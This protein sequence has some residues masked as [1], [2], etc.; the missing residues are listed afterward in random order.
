MEVII[1]TADEVSEFAESLINTVREPLMSLNQD[2]R[3]V[4]VSR[5]FYE[6]FK[7]NPEETIGQLIYDLGNKQWDIPQL[8]ELLE[9]ILPHQSSF[10]NYEVEHDFT[11]I[12]RRIMLLNVRQ[13][14]R[15]SGKEKIILL[16]IEDITERKE[17]EAGL[18]KTRKELEVIKKIAD[19]AREFAESIINTVREPLLSL[20]QDL[21]V[22]TVS[23]SFYEVFKVNPEETIGQLVYNLGNKQW[24]IPQLRELLETILPQQSSFENYEVE[25]DFTTIGKRIMLLNARQIQ[26]ASGKEKI[27]LLAIEDITVRKEIEKGLIASEEKWRKLFQILPVGVSVIDNN[28]YITDYNSASKRIM[29]LSDKNFDKNDFNERVYKRPDD[30]LLDPHEHP[31]NI[32]IRDKKVVKGMELKTLNDDGS[33]LWLKVSAVPLCFRDSACVV[34]TDDITERK[35]IEAG[36]EKTRKELEVIKKI[37]DDASE[38]AESI[39]NTV[40]EPLLSLDQD[41][42]V[43]TVSRSFYEVFKVNPEETIGQL[44]YNLGNKQWDIPQLREL[45]ETILPQQSSFENYEVEHDFTTIGKRIMLL[46]ARQIQRASGKEKIILLAI[47]D[48]TVRKEIEK[49][50]IASEEKW[51]KLFQI[52]PVGVSVIDNNNYITDYNSASKRIMG[53]SDKNF[54]KNDFNERVYKRPDDTLLDPHEHPI[55]IAIRDK[56]VVKGMELK[57]LNDDGSILWLKVSAVPLCFRNSSCVMVTDDITE[58]KVIEAALT[59]SER[60]FFTLAENSTDMIIRFDTAFQRIY[61]NPAVE[62]TFGIPGSNL[63]GKTP[64]ELLF[65]KNEDDKSYNALKKAMETGENQ[66]VEVSM[67]QSTGDRWFQSRIMPEFNDK[68]VIESLLSITRELTGY[69][70][71]ANELDLYRRQLEK[72]VEIRT[73]E[74]SDSEKRYRDIIES[75]TDYVYQVNIDENKKI[76]TIYAESCFKVTGYYSSEFVQDSSLWLNIVYEKDNGLV[77]NFISDINKEKEPFKRSIIYRINHKDGSL[78]WIKNIIVVH[79]K[80]GGGF[81]GYDGVISDIT[82]IKNAEDEIKRLN[83]NLMSAQEDERQRVSKDL[84]DGVGQTILA[85]KINIEAYQQNPVLFAGRIDVGLDFLIKASQ[86]L[87]DVYMD[88]YPTMLN[89]LG[90]EMTIRWLVKNLMQPA[91]ISSILNIN[92]MNRL[93]HELEINIYRIIQEILSNILKHSRAKSFRLNLFGNE[94]LVKLTVKDDGIGV[95]EK[96]VRSTSTGCGMGNIK[97]RVKQM[98]GEITFEMNKPKGTGIS[99]VFYIVN[100]Y[101]SVS[102]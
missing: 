19:D 15:A 8:R 55:N 60:D 9:T 81:S 69:K 2:L 74:L 35:E 48:I 23:R 36:L 61:S 46:N 26:R 20:D 79:K 53:L 28:N 82:E 86:E 52:L 71:I 65:I 99:I 56:K 24:D 63:I 64:I 68:G 5:S 31:I 16:A 34:V 84:H 51:R 80:S 41:L 101:P 45:L 77:K 21:R 90:I 98:N 13:I 89:D 12:G 67:Q 94:K 58:R 11:T 102:S 50:L 44:V 39:I 59:K 66:E 22:V 62:K 70:I 43:V 14:Q 96:S 18:E 83:H 1:K 91:G 97:T 72:L 100:L 47:E 49:G 54:D 92:L 10:E 85:A 88:L 38:F 93:S 3:V 29:G 57:T 75:I 7:V 40:R 27:I 95:D 6:V 76:H 30:T 4:S 42:R 25:H 37:A 73:S 32:A 78:K 17:I 87:R 33:I